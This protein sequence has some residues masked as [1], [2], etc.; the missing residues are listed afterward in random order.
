MRPP[1]R[2]SSGSRSSRFRGENGVL[3]RHTA[4]KME[5]SY[6]KAVPVAL[7]HSLFSSFR[8][9]TFASDGT[10]PR[11]RIR[12]LPARKIRHSGPIPN[13]VFP[14]RQPRRYPESFREGL[15]DVESGTVLLLGTRRCFRWAFRILFCYIQPTSTPP[16]RRGGVF[17]VFRDRP[18]RTLRA[19]PAS[20]LRTSSGPV[21]ARTP[22]QH[23]VIALTI[24]T[25]ER[26]AE[27]RFPHRH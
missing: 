23:I 19:D 10:A 6:L 17:P 15:S 26:Q 21:G 22:P 25:H 7:L 18:F 2:H 4:G 1:K 3:A 27:E 11:S 14:F 5:N 12:G 24:T 16:G 13:G 8:V 9:V 20:A